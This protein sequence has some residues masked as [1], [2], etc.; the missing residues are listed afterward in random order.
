MPTKKCNWL[1]R[2]PTP[3]KGRGRLQ[4]AAKRLFCGQSVV[5]T[6]QVAE[7]GY[8]EQLLLRGKR[9]RPADYYAVRTASSSTSLAFMAEASAAVS[10]RTKVCYPFG[11]KHGR[12]WAVNRRDFITLLG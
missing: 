11:G 9:L 4:Q 12:S 8:C 1:Q 5:T 2:P 7:W 6:A 10:C 3:S